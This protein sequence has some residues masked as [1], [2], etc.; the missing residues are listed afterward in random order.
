M[1]HHVL[2]FKDSVKIVHFI[3]ATKPWHHPYN[4]ATKEVTPLPETGHNK[5]YLQIWWDIFM[6]F[7]QPTLDPSLVST[8]APVLLPITWHYLQPIICSFRECWFVS[9]NWFLSFMHLSFASVCMTVNYHLHWTMKDAMWQMHVLHSFC[10]L[11]YWHVTIKCWYVFSWF[12]SLLRSNLLRILL[13][14]KLY[15]C[16]KMKIT[17]S[18]I[19][20]NYIC[21]PGL[22]VIV[23]RLSFKEAKPYCFT[24]LL[25]SVFQPDTI[26]CLVWVDREKPLTPYTLTS[27]WPPLIFRSKGQGSHYLLFANID[28]VFMR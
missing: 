25:L 14:P 22:T 15:T 1:S 18:K 5:D 20:W 8:S 28:E 19:R 17:V 21:R 4:T 6:S 9:W 16:M 27:Q 2:R 26:C 13:K 10:N 3:G 7:V 11:C 12:Y 24:N 23:I